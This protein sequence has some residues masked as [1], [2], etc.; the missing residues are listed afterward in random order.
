MWEGFQLSLYF[1]Y[2]FSFPYNFWLK[3]EKRMVDVK[4][5]WCNAKQRISRFLTLFFGHAKG[6]DVA[7]KIMDTHEEAGLLSQA[8]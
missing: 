1:L 6:H 2:V 7:K 5:M 3:R 4:W 8:W